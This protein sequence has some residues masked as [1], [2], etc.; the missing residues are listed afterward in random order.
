MPKQPED[1]ASMADVREGV[2]AIDRALVELL[3]TRFGYMRAAARIKPSR[4][5][6]RDED[7]KAE[8]IE[9]VRADAE[10]RGLPADKLAAIWDQ[11]VETSIS[12]EFEEWDRTRA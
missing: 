7:R 2:D 8:V 10:A 5:T 12:Y 3:E 11:L 6:V 1:C 9:A 4:D